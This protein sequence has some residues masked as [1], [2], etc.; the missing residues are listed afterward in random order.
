ME[1]HGSPERI[2]RYLLGDL[3]EEEREQIEAQLL[4]D[5]GM[6]GAISSLQD[7]L[8]DDY[9]LD[10][11]SDRDRSLFDLNFVLS[12]E[13]LHKLRCSTALATYTE[14]NFGKTTSMQASA[15]LNPQPG[16]SA[17]LGRHRLA[18]AISFGVLLLTIGYFGW[19]AYE[20]YQLQKRLTELQVKQQ[21]VEQYLANLNA[22]D[23]S[24]RRS[25]MSTLRLRPLLRGSNDMNRV[26]ISAATEILQLNLEVYENEFLVYQAMIETDE[27]NG[28]YSINNLR[29][30]TDDGRKVVVLYLPSHLLPSGSYQIHLRGTSAQQQTSDIGDY[31]F[32]LALK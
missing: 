5:E 21:Q 28:L 14:A 24:A 29:A 20:R 31:P 25:S 13:R 30:Q 3:D 11:L 10:V 22:Q 32:Q 8:I 17:F 26:A 18:V 16:F 19:K 4:A 23:L 6:L 12:P 15:P 1:R 7:E 27:G 2:R 9:A